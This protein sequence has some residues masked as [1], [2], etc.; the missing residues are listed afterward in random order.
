M[1]V[2]SRVVETFANSGAIE[3]FKVKLSNRNRLVSLSC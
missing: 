1:L 2:F 3:A